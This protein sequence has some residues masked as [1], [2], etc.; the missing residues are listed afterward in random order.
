MNC[1]NVMRE[2]SNYIDGDLDPHMMEDFE[3]HLEHC[4]EC[5]IILDQTKKFIAILSGSKLFDLPD[6]VRARLRAAVRRKIEKK[7]K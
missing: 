4:E 7:S 1:K 2:L 5:S 3:R 6:D